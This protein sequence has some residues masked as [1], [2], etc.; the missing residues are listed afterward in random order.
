MRLDDAEKE[1]D[2][3]KSE[4]QTVERIR[5]ETADALSSLQGV[6]KEISNDHE[7]E[8]ASYQHSCAQLQFKVDVR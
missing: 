5:Q 7:K 6:L 1:A 8:S 4:A 2:Q 3:W